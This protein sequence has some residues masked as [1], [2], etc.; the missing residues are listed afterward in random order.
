MSDL[1]AMDG[2]LLPSAESKRRLRGTA[3]AGLTVVLVFFGG[4]GLW[5]ATAPL[6]SAVVA[7]GQ[8]VVASNRQL[9]QHREGGIVAAI[10]ARDGDRVVAGQELLRLDEVQPRAEYEAAM[11]SVRDLEA[12]AAR[13]RAQRELR[14][15]IAFPQWL[16]A[17]QDDPRV[18][19]LVEVQTK[20]FSS[21]R[22]MYVGQLDILASR[23]EQL[24][25]VVDGLSLEIEAVERQRNFI[26]EELVGVRGLFDKGLAMKPRLLALEREAVALDGQRGRLVAERARNEVAAGETRLQAINLRNTFVSE[27]SSELNDVQARLELARQRLAAAEDVLKR[28]T[29]TAP[30]SGVIVNA[31]V[32]TV[33]GVAPPGETLM[34][35]VPSEDRV[36]AEVQVR[37]DEVDSVSPGMMARLTLV[38]FSHRDLA[39]V[40]GAVSVVSAD[41]LVDPI[42]GAPFFKVRIDVDE[43]SLSG[44]ALDEIVP[45]MPLEAMIQ[46]GARTALDYAIEPLKRSFDR[47]LRE[48]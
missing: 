12:H 16:L 30:M 39:A 34:E 46:I 21:R 20:A 28:L 47:A 14:E 18:A 41:A 26:E 2:R 40:E 1:V 8:F 17:I 37:P 44:V 19:E 15:K 31:K 36:V 6:N 35:I 29:I 48:Q 33:G 25:E 10:N 11:M 45:G 13:L 5:A 7:G 27:A 24:R 9:V 3:L 38:A 4:F 23:E 22:E 42:T 32:H 43:T